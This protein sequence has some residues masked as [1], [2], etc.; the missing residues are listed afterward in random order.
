MGNNAL[1]EFKARYYYEDYPKREYIKAKI[2]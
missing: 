1:V 2:E